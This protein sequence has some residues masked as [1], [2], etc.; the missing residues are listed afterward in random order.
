LLGGRRKEGRLALLE[1]RGAGTPSERRTA[2]LCL[3][4]GKRERKVSAQNA[5]E[6]FS[7]MLKREKAHTTTAGL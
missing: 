3:H 2:G 6:N 1:R 4:R 5:K 7:T